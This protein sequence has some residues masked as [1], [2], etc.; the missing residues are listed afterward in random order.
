ME[1]P[2][3]HVLERNAGACGHAQTVAGIDKSVGARREDAPGAA[4]G[5]QR[6]LRL[7]DHDLAGLHLQ[8]RHAQYHPVGVADQVERHPLDEELGARADV[9]LIQGV[10]H[11]V[12]GAVGRGTGALHRLLA[13]IRRM[14][15]EWP[16]IDGAVGVAIER[17]PEMFEFVDDFR[18]RAAHV[19]DRVLVAKPVGALDRVVHVPEPVIL[20]H[21][22]QRRADAALR[23]NGVGTRREH[24][25]QHRDR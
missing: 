2:E 16:L 8:R 17:H 18:R 10:Q 6:R 19:F 21:V 23:G 14:P 13:E 25:R 20:T 22:A 9:A 7:Q 5:E 3:L 4:G 12:A 1:L 11:G 24:L 15:A